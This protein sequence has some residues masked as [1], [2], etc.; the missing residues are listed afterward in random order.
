[1]KK[2]KL[3]TSIA[4]G[5]LMGFL[6]LPGLLHAQQAIKLSDP[7]VAS[8]AVTANQIDIDY[9]AI[10]LKKSA[11][12]EVLNFAKTMTNDHKAVIGQAV[13][14]ATKLNVTPQTNDLT[15]K[16]LSD[17]QKTKKQLEAK[18]GKEFDKAYINNEVAYHKAVIDAVENGFA[19]L[20]IDRFHPILQHRG[21]DQ[22]EIL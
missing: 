5:A 2:N 13:A 7:E 11:N 6:Q 4:A 20:R 18:K 21:I 12:T 8:V 19:L 15:K 14:L 16:L 22:G 10:A 17:A 1:M 3:F 9:A